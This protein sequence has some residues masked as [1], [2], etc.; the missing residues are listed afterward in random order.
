MRTVLTRIKLP[1]LLTH[2]PVRVLTSDGSD[3]R[4]TVHRKRHACHNSIPA[5]AR[6]V[7]NEFLGTTPPSDMGNLLLAF[8]FTNHEKHIIL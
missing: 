2:Q 7:H 6:H 4:T 3:R 1:T 8:F 5:S